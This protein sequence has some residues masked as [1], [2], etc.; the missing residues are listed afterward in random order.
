MNPG[1]NIM[2]AADLL[3]EQNELIPFLGV[4]RNR[5]AGHRKFKSPL[6][7]DCSRDNG[8]VS[9]DLLRLVRIGRFAPDPNACGP[10]VRELRTSKVEGIGRFSHQGRHRD[11]VGIRLREPENKAKSAELFFDSEELQIVGINSGKL[12]GG[13]LQGEGKDIDFGAF[14]IL[15][16]IGTGT[17][18]GHAG[19]FPWDNSGRI[20]Q[21]VKNTV[22]DLLHNIID[23]NRSA[24]ILEATAAMIAGCGGEQGPVSGQDIEAQQSQFLSKGNKGMKNLLIQGFSNTNAEVGEG[25]R[26]GNTIVANAGKKAVVASTLGIP[27]DKTEVL[28]ESNPFQITEQVEKEK[29]D[30]IIARSTEDGISLSSDGADEGEIDD[31]SDQLGDAT[32]NGA[33]VVDMNVLLSKLVMRK[34]TSLFLGKWFAV[35]AVDK[36]IDFPELS[37]NITN[38]EQGEIVHLKNS[39][40][41][42]G[43]S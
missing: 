28:D 19:F 39:R 27:K 22:M 30:R 17:L 1:V 5:K 6:R 42:R 40:V 37:D 29:G 33:V 8:I 13:I 10:I 12:F 43:H 31:G 25:S 11:I 24:G 36:R 4:A 2:K 16:K 20:L 41:S 21:P 3:I 38:R 7:F 15:R 18:N 14:D 32:A 23:G 9:E 26:T 35:P 34:P